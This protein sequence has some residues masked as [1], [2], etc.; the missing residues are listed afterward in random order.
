MQDLK[1]RLLDLLSMFAWHDGI[2]EQLCGLGQ[3]ERYAVVSRS[4]RDDSDHWI[5]G[6][7]DDMT[8][9]LQLVADVDEEWVFVGLL[10]LSGEPGEPVIQ[11]PV[12]VRY[13]AGESHTT[14]PIGLP[15]DALSGVGT[16]DVGWAKGLYDETE[17]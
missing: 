1:R 14:R 8:G 13:E 3:P 12:H 11:V 4:V 9:A 16:H 17:E 2:V 15:E 5:D 10:D 6:F 7:A